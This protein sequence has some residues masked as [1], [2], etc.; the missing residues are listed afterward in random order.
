MTKADD[1]RRRTRA[2]GIAVALAVASLCVSAAMLLV[3]VD[4]LS[5]SAE[6]AGGDPPVAST[7]GTPTIV[8][9]DCPAAAVALDGSGSLDPDG[10]P[11]SYSWTGPFGSASGATP[12]VALFPGDHVI[13]LVVTDG[14]G[15]EA[16]A[17]HAITVV[18]GVPCPGDD[19]PPTIACPGD[20]TVSTDPGQ[21]S[22][23]VTF[24]VTATDDRD[25]NPTIACDPPSGSTFSKG[26]TTVTCTATDA[27][28]NVSEPC[29]FTVTVV[30]DE[31]PTLTIVSLSPHYLWPPN[32]KMQT[33]SITFQK[34][35]NCLPSPGISVKVRSN[36]PDDAAGNGDGHTT[37]DVDGQDGFTSPV[38][39]PA[40]R[41]VDHGDG[42]CTATFALR[43]ERAGSGSGRVYGVEIVATDAAG[44]AS[45]VAGATI[46]VAHDHGPCAVCDAGD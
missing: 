19:V 9:F 43:A 13:Q 17:F 28:G 42:T 5:P 22:A 18:E 33:V 46:R 31:P 3:L 25:P 29:S 27:G 20:I 26:T 30:D 41:I 16:T 21:C 10:T 34:G 15:D 4:V 2:G 36:E 11:L 12:T 35:D 14:D 8:F 40:S 39:I 7:A 32:H 1:S 24:V 37:G 45:E 44:N 23:A 6:G 38:A